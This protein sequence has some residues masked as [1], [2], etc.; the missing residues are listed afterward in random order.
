MGTGP[1]NAAAH[2][3]GRLLNPKLED[4]RPVFISFDDHHPECF[5]FPE[6]G[7]ETEK[8][9]CPEEAHK[10]LHHCRGSKLYAKKSGPGCVCV[11]VSGDAASDTECPELL[12]TQ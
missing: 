12:D 5:T 4:G 6:K 3:G 1:E 10:V 9:E 11:P 8:V 7:K 2:D